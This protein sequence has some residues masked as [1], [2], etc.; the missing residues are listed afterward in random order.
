VLTAMM[1][2]ARLY[3]ACPVRV[4]EPLPLSLAGAR[5][6]GLGSPVQYLTG[7]LL[8]RVLAP[9]LP[10]DA[11]AYLGVTM[12]DLYPGPGWNFVF[13]QGSFA[14]R[15][16]VYSL[17]RY[18]PE[19]WGERDTAAARLALVA[20]SCKVL[21][22]ETGHMLSMRHCTRYECLMNGAN[23]LGELDRSP[24]WLCPVCLRKLHFSLGF[25][26]VERY[27]KLGR[28]F[29]SSG[30]SEWASWADARVTALHPAT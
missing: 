7:T 19:F 8:H 15:I 4:A 24:I 21:A 30:F 6:A 17:V 23:N 27:R 12:A 2:F 14:N 22:H 29:R 16:G 18:T 1:E 10:D 9:R 13:G 3:F 11:L 26:V 28:F 5:S 25:E 20:R